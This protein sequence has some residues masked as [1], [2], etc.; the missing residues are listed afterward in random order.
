MG[1]L[2]KNLGYYAALFLFMVSSSQAS[3]TILE[4]DDWTIKL[5]GFVEFDSITDSTRSLT[6]VPGNTP[7][8]RAGTFNGSNGRTQF[9]IRNSRLA[10]DVAAPM[11][12]G[13]KSRGYLEMDFLGY[14]AAPPSQTEAGFFNN[15]SLRVRHAF[16]EVETENDWKFL[17]GQTWQILGWQPYYFLNTVDV[18]PLAGQLYGRTVQAHALKQAQFNDVTLQGMIGVSRP[19]ERDS[20]YP[21]LD[22]GLRVAYEGRKSGFVGGSTGKQRTQ[23]MS[24]GVSGT[25]REIEIPNVGGGV[26]DNTKYP[27]G[28]FAID[29]MIPIIASSDGKDVS[30][31]LS[32]S[33][34]FT[35]GSGYGDEFNSWT[36]N[37]ANP[38]SSAKNGTAAA[39]VAAGHPADLDAG[40]GDFDA[41]SAF[42]LMHLAT[43]NTQLQYTF[44]EKNWIDGGYAQLFSNNVDTLVAT[45]GLTS[46]G[47]IPYDREQ[48]MF[49]NLFH[50][51]TS[52]LRMGLEY[53]FT[54]TTYGDGETGRNNRYMAS[55]WFFF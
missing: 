43:F 12:D 5:S 52:Q 30:H 35:T 15:P 17:A 1:E 26:S 7:I 8:D 28:G 27:A 9:S 24:I 37:V 19:P 4:K 51:F 41:N 48:V 14:D 2:M 54:R 25:F 36:G 13:V 6:E 38:L 29:A 33:G 23:P 45:N 44:N 20:S 39:L 32:I 22:G 3:Q 42:H 46:S 18:A 21:S 55:A 16:L 53:D 50:D 31:T 49:V 34:E 11:V 10:L 47:N 40:V